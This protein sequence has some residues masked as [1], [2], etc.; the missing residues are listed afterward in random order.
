MK[1]LITIISFIPVIFLGCGKT[2]SPKL[3]THNFTKGQWIGGLSS[4]VGS[5][6]LHLNNYTATKHEFEQDDNYA[7]ENSKSSSITFGNSSISF[8]IPVTRQDPYSIYI[9]DVNSTRLE[10]DA[11]DGYGFVTVYFESDGTEIIGDCVNNIICVCGSPKL[12]L[13]NIQALVPVAFSPKNGSV[14]IGSAP[15]ATFTSDI[16]ESGPCVNN[17]CAFF[18]DIIAPNKNSDMQKAVANAM[19]DYIDQYSSMISIPFNQYLQKLGVT[20][21]IVSIKI[22]TNG[23]MSVE[24]NE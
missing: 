12:D 10:T 18:C 7:Y 2:N 21:A 5:L 6:K 14:A 8:D 24:D 20:G 15:G 16:S 22:A 17:A 9:N 11:H 4:T 3:V 23:D 13:S 1:K 19:E